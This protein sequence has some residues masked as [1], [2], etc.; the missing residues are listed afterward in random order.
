MDDNLSL[1]TTAL[2]VIVAM[3]T[4]L[5]TGCLGGQPLGS[6]D[7]G[8]PP[9]N[10]AGGG[11]A[12][13]KQFGST[14]ILPI[15]N[16]WQEAFNK[17]HPEITIAVSGGGSGTGIA[18]LAARTCNI[19]NASR[20]IKPEEMQAA[21]ARGVHPH[22]IPIAY[23]GIAVIVN[24]ANPIRE[25]TL[26]Q[27]SDL[28]TGTLRRWEQVGV[29]GGGEVHL[30]ARDSASGT[31]ESFKAM[32]I[33][34]NDTDKSR[35]YAPEA[36]QQ[37]SNEGVLQTV[38]QVPDAIGYVGMGYI[39][40]KVK[41]LGIIPEEGQPA[42]FPSETTVREGSYPI[43]RKLY[44]YTDGEPTGVVKTY[45]DWCLGPEGQALVKAAGFIPLRPLP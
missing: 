39:N 32:V 38:I 37:S 4:A 5:L 9:V 22:E 25:L 21:Q 1:I 41:V 13:L 2:L 42:V 29:P 14:T 3:A 31:F 30:V 24:P 7:A 34:L 45:V 44:M 8:Q 20:A 12:H 28:Y 10:I 40:D 43:A 6:A 26:R 15:A 18:Q 36:L 33:T 27:L 16:R 19:A 35:N 11:G 17:L 23:D